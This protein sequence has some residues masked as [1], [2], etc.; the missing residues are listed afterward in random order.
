MASKRQMQQR[1]LRERG[2]LGVLP[3]MPEIDSGEPAAGVSQRMAHWARSLEYTSVQAA[4]WLYGAYPQG[5]PYAE[6]CAEASA[7]RLVL[8]RVHAIVD[9][10]YAR[11]M[12]DRAYL[13]Y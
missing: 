11:Y 1:H 8:R 6:A 4:E 9:A 13:S 3:L 5:C 2:I 7:C 12:L 10:Q